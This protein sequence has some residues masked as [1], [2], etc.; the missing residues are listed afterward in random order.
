MGLQTSRYHEYGK[1]FAFKILNILECSSVGQSTTLI[2]WGSVVRVHSFQPSKAGTTCF[3]CFI[4]NPTLLQNFVL[5]NAFAFAGWTTLNAL[6]FRSQRWGSVVRPVGP[7]HNKLFPALAKNKP[8]ACFFYASPH[9]FQP[10]KAGTTCFFYLHNIPT[11]LQ[12]FV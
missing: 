6:R 3:F 4:F 12:N 7:D 2:R 9:S 8:P 10:S 5:S 1:A 11:L